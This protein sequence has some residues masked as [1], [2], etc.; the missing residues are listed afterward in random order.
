MRQGTCAACQRPDQ[1]LAQATEDCECLVCED[2]A[3]AFLD[4]NECG[5]CGPV[6]TED[7]PVDDWDEEAAP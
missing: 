4:A 1:R 6:F 3:N 7:E 2:C 5:I